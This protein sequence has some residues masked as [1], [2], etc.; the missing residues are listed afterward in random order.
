MALIPRD[1]PMDHPC[2]RCAGSKGT[3]QAEV[4][5]CC[6]LLLVSIFLRQPLPHSQVVVVLRCLHSDRDTLALSEPLQKSCFPVLLPLRRVLP[7]QKVPFTRAPVPIHFPLL[8]KPVLL[9][10]PRF[11]QH[12]AT[13]AFRKSSGW[14]WPRGECRREERCQP[15]AARRRAPH[16]GWRGGR[17]GGASSV[18]AGG[19]G[20]LPGPAG[21]APS[22]RAG[23]ARTGR[24]PASSAAA[25]P[26]RPSEPGAGA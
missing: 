20:G 13:T 4:C 16:H 19:G 11:G 25:G 21:G 1:D 23:P 12:F 9:I 8:G 10:L 26:G 6:G 2:V 15:L 14:W 24:R 7:I 3:G 22:L 18:G 17:G 5:H